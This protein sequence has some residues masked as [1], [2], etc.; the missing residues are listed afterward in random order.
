LKRSNMS[1]R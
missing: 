1:M